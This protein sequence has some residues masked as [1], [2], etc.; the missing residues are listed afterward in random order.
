MLSLGFKTPEAVFAQFT[1]ERFVHCDGAL[2]EPMLHFQLDTK[3]SQTDG[4]EIAEAY[5][6]VVT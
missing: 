6:T 1:L 3:F 5:T 4:T 2:L